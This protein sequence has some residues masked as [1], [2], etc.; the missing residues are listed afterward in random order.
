MSHSIAF[1]NQKGGVGK[2]TLVANAGAYWGRQGCRVLLID[3]APQSHLS[4]HFHAGLDQRDLEEHNIYQVLRGGCSFADT[5]VPLPDEMVDLVP[6]HI[7][8]SAAEWELGQEVGRE[9]ILRDLLRE[10]LRDAHYDLV[11]IDCPPSLGLL[12]LNALAAVDDV[13]VPVQAEFFALQGMAQLMRVVELVSGRLHAGLRW[14]IVVPTL[15]DLRTNLGREVIAELERHVPGKVTENFL[16]KR[17]KVAEAPSHGQSI[18]TYAPETRAAEEFR[19]LCQE[20]TERLG[21]K[22]P[23]AS[24][25]GC[26]SGSGEG[27][28]G[29]DEP[30]AES[31]PPTG[32][33]AH[34]ALLDEVAGKP[35]P[36][37]RSKGGSITPEGTESEDASGGA[38]FSPKP[39]LSDRE[40]SEGESPSTVP[41]APVN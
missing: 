8:L 26:P 5:V 33:A 30:P 4:L 17:V 38:T 9:V 34:R 1:I 15:V 10:F 36:Q 7:D 11:L 18:F 28:D 27:G 23:S 3:L 6:A 22:M 31:P 19:K 35:M 21:L 16:T 14:R 40:E 24:E 13:V 2:T 37:K 29:D 41:Q 20:L 39:P 32:F 25:R 12:S